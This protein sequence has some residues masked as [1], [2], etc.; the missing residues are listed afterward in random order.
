MVI[1]WAITPLQGAIFGTGPVTIQSPAVFA[2]S[3][4]LIPAEQQSAL[5]DSKILHR[6]Y[7]TK[8]LGQEFPPFTTPEYA[9]RPF[10]LAE[11]NT[12]AGTPSNWTGTTTKFWTDLECRPAESVPNKVFPGYYDFLNGQGCNASEIMAFNAFPMA[13]A[14]LG[15][16]SSA[17]SD[18]FMA[19]PTCT[20]EFSNQ[21]LAILARREP[22]QRTKVIAEDYDMTA[23]FCTTSYWKQEVQVTVSSET[24]RPD[25]TSIVPKGPVEKLLTTEFNNTGFEYM[26]GSSVSAVQDASRDYAANLIVDQYAKVNGTGLNWPLSPLVG[27]VIG[28]KERPVEDYLDE[29]LLAEGFRKVHQAAFVHAYDSLLSKA[30]ETSATTE[31]STEFIMYGILVSRLFAAI[32]EGLLLAVGASALLLAFLAGRKRSNLGSDPATLGDVIDL[33]QSS[34]DLSDAS[35]GHGGHGGTDANAN[36]DLETT[37]VYLQHTCRQ[38]GA[39]T[40]IRIVN[41]AGLQRALHGE[42][43]ARS[44]EA[45]EFTPVKPFALRQVSG[46]LVVPI[47]AGCL[48]ALVYLRAQEQRLGGKFKVPIPK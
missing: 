22:G 30:A 37:R 11:G 12:S 40:E 1:F 15:W 9:L 47:I 23:L 21:F 27:F 18:Q 26:L 33:L 41:P 8:Y 4:D 2:A 32:V 28:G 19:R 3:S 25:N 43:G 20:S 46:A 16:H 17:H 34:P 10:Q 35:M 42:K 39:A 31:G 38:P 36:P 29:T 14:Y 45:D 13:M 7:A 24:L 48:V 44:L 6:L 5:I